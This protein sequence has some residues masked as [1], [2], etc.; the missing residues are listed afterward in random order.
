VTLVYRFDSEIS[1][2]MPL[3]LKVE[4]NTHEH[5]SVFDYIWKSFKV[6]SPCSMGRQNW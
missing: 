1:P 6:K 4:I 2:I 3:R 5:F